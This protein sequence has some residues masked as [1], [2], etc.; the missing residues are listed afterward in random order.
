MTARKG[1]IVEIFTDGACSGNPGP[2]G[3]GSLLRYGD[4]TKEIS[5]C[6]PHTTNNRMEMMAVI[7]A[8]RQLK[9]PCSVKLYTDSKYVMQGMTEW[10]SG[11]IRRNWV[12][13]QKRPVVNRDLWEQILSLSK[14]HQIEWKWVRGHKGHPE[15]ERC[16]RLARNALEKCKRTSRNQRSSK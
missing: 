2:G 16:D 1:K 6:A 4:V 8:L 14:P 13:S 11:W 9:R 7:E 3:Y 15:N 10:V 5:G 12:N